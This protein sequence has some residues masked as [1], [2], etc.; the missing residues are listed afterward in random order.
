VHAALEHVHLAAHVDA[1]DAQHHAQLREAAL[2]V[3]TESAWQQAY[4]SQASRKAVQLQ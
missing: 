3:N 2:W 1:A 4:K